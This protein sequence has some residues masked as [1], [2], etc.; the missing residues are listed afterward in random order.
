MHQFVL[1]FCSSWLPYLH[2][3]QYSLIVSN[4]H[5]GAA[6]WATCSSN[7]MQTTHMIFGR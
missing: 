5:E 1:R 3:S 6:G 4:K 2:T 7:N